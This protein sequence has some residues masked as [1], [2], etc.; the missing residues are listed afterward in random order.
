ML[1]TLYPTGISPASEIES[2]FHSAEILKDKVNILLIPGR[3]GNIT[4]L[5]N[6]IVHSAKYGCRKDGICVMTLGAFKLF[7]FKN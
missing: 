7:E 5:D 6:G 2:I 1:E 4:G 3:P